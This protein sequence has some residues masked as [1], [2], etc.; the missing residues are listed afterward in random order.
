MRV[1]DGGETW[2]EKIEI[3][4]GD[5]GEYKQ[6]SSDIPIAKYNNTVES[7][8]GF[9]A[10]MQKTGGTGEQMEYLSLYL[11]NGSGMVRVLEYLD[12]AHAVS[13]PDNPI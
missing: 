1:G 6:V 4:S 2:L 10:V 8:D 9:L 11:Y 13:F 5:S 12:I 3:I 7:K